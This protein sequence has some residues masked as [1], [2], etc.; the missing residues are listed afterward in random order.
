MHVVETNEERGSDEPT[1][2]GTGVVVRDGRE[3][4]GS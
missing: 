2:G 3:A 4:I 1:G